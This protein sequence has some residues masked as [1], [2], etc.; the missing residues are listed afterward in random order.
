MIVIVIVGAIVL[1]PCIHYTHTDTEC[2]DRV[3]S[4]DSKNA[5]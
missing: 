3:F 5:K 2:G 4:N 1:I